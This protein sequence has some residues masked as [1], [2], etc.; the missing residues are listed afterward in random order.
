MPFLRRAADR[1]HASVTIGWKALFAAEALLG[2]YG[3][4][5][6]G[7]VAFITTVLY[8]LFANIRPRELY[9]ART[10]AERLLGRSDGDMA[11]IQ[12]VLG[13]YAEHADEAL[14]T[15]MVEFQLGALTVAY[16][17]VTASP[18]LEFPQGH[19][20]SSP[21][22]Q[23][24]INAFVAEGLHPHDVFELRPPDVEWSGQTPATAS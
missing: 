23:A 6:G 17:A 18:L 2:I 15:Q 24:T 21:E 22:R 8:E 14:V 20:R 1:L 3:G 7:G 5:F 11:L 9:A 10:K 19:W 13:T 12:H 16:E 4:Y